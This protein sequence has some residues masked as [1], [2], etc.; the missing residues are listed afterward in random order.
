MYLRLVVH[1]ADTRVPLGRFVV[2]RARGGDGGIELLEP[3]Q[4]HGGVEEGED[5][6][7]EGLPVCCAERLVG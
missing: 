2:V 3:A 5:V 7:V 1:V 4:V 6:G